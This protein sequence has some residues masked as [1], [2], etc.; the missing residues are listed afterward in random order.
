M[1]DAAIVPEVA[2]RA[3]PLDKLVGI[4]DGLQAQE[5]PPTPIVV[6]VLSVE[7]PKLHN[8]TL[9]VGIKDVPV[10]KLPPLSI[11]ATSVL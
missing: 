8:A 1:G 9:G 5:A 3:V 7:V 4:P 11:D 2:A 10:R 6:G